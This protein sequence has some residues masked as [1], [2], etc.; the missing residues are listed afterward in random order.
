MIPEDRR[1]KILLLLRQ[2]GAVK[3]SDLSRDF[4]VSELTVRRD[5]DLME[6]KGLL[7]RSHGGALLRQALPTEPS[8]RE[9]EKHLIR[10]KQAI[11]RAAVD[12]VEDGDTVFIN[13]GSTNLQVLRLLSSRRV[14]V[15]TSH[16]GGLSELNPT[17]MELLLVGGF[18][19]PQSHS[20]VGSFAH[21]AIRRSFAQKAIIGVDGVSQTKGLTTPNEQE[22]EVTRLMVEHTM[23]P[24]IVVADHTKMGVVSNFLSLPL[25]RADVLVTDRKTADLVDEEMLHSLGL[26]LMFVDP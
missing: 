13:S 24:V 10:E 21:E 11:A 16:A 5:L 19:R 15:I 12:L 23:G 17:E 22:A 26:E 7:E 20:L 3:V 18:Y 6:S 14:R 9:K 8:Y 25:E 4:Q 2:L 1:E